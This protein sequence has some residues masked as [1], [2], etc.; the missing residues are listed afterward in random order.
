MDDVRVVL[1]IL[2]VINVDIVAVAAQVVASQIH[3]HDVFGI[4]FGVVAQELCSLTVFLLIACTFCCTGNGVDECLPT[5]DTA[6]GLGTAAKD[7]ETAEV[8]IEQVG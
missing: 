1:N 8:E 4:L 7:T 5:F 2:V 3:Q 6:V